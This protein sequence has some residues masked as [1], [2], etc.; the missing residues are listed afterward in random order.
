MWKTLLRFFLT[1]KILLIIKECSL[2]LMSTRIIIA[3]LCLYNFEGFSTWISLFFC[4]ILRCRAAFVPPTEAVSI[5][6]ALCVSLV[7]VHSIFQP[8]PW[9]RLR[10][11]R[12]C[13]LVESWAGITVLPC[14]TYAPLR[15]CAFWC[16]RQT[17]KLG[18]WR[19]PWT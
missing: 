8:K 15:P 6:Q 1:R 13:T 4:F 10:A 9:K 17:R 16:L 3:S 18:H 5:E 19:R 2:A 7:V 14:T 12:T 11:M